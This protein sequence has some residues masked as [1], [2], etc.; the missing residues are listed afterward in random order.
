MP[1]PVPVLLPQL[2]PNEAEVRLD[3][4]PVSNGQWISQGDLLATLETTKSTLELLAA[5]DGYVIGLTLT[6]GEM[7]HSGDILCY[8]A[9]NPA[10][11]PPQPDISQNPNKT[12]DT[13]AL[14]DGL[15]ITRK[16]M[17][18]AAANQL[19]LCSLPQG[20]L[21]TETTIKEMLQSQTAREQRGTALPTAYNQKSLII[22]GGGGHGKSLIELVKCL[23]QY[24]LVGILD[25]GLLE[26]SLIL[27]IPVIG[28]HGQLEPLAA[29]GLRLAINA[30]GG[31]GN[32][33]PRLK[34]FNRL[35]EV[36]IY[37][38]N[39]IHP[40]AFVEASATLSDG[41][42]VFSQAYVGSSVQL[43]VGVIANTGSIISHDCIIGDY[44]NLSPG[45]LLA[46][47][48]RIG[49]R[50][51]VGMGVTVNLGVTIGPDARIGNNA[52]VKADV[53]AGYM[54]HAGS[55][56]PPQ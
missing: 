12:G 16:A 33:A 40:T 4:L 9:E 21:V 22:Y 31:I 50:C 48:V 19:D 51:L 15:R 26:G 55:I 53:P 13:P 6:A 43:G 32:L 3:N 56:W 35:R 7:A 28:G 11:R 47:G 34:V 39:V 30:V 37:C 54:V 41:I 1:E 36:G 24:D 14:P 45:A 8:L 49:E 17:E 44:A 18:L 5:E 2:N 23:A 10:D 42:Q 20:P 38:P 29:H 25:D 46:G 27:G 52:T